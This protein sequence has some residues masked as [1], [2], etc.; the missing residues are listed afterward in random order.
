[1]RTTHDLD[2]L[3]WLCRDLKLCGDN[4]LYVA[5]I[6]LHL[7]IKQIFPPWECLVYQARLPSHFGLPYSGKLLHGLDLTVISENLQNLIP[8]LYFDH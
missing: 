7:R 4:T 6:S 8:S 5:K 3:P 2:V 1:M